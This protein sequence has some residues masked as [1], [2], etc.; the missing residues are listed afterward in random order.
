MN[1]MVRCSSGRGRRIGQLGQS[2]VEFLVAMAVLL[3]LFLGVTYAGRYSDIQ[4]SAVQAS[5][6]AAAQRVM[7]PDV[8]QL[9]DSKIQDQMRARFFVQGGYLH[10]GRL[11]SDDSAVG[12][13]SQ[14]TP[15]T[16]R[17]FSFDP[18]LKSPNNVSLKFQSTALNGGAA[19][20]ALNF[21]AS[22]A[23]KTYKGGTV[24]QVEVDLVNKMDL[25]VPSPNNIKIAAATAVVGD[26]LS[27]S[28]AAATRS[29]AAKSVL[30]T[31][32]PGIVTNVID[33]GMKLFEPHGP[34]F[35]CIKPD[36]VPNGS[37]EGYAPAG[38]C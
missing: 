29:A 18:L 16:W 6:Y 17:D 31:R 1:E 15:A 13:S 19:Q 37:L 14:A 32:V 21:A 2:M 35:G 8:G 10:G 9:S 22:S 20:A 24:A 3:P 30:S 28:G 12:I 7:Q 38:G 36:V 33:V 27:S 34:K 11:Q 25:S 23:N 5:R 26:S 4:Q